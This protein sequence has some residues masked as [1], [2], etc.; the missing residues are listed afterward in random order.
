MSLVLTQSEEA[1]SERQRTLPLLVVSSLAL[2]VLVVA[3][4]PRPR[5]DASRAPLPVLTAVFADDAPAPTPAERP[6]ESEPKPAEDAR[7]AQ[8]PS[9][10][11][12]VT[13]RPAAVRAPAPAAAPSGAESP[14]DAPA[15]FTST[16]L[17]S[18]G[19][20]VAVPPGGGGAPGGSAR[21]A[22]PGP[23]YATR[24]QAGPRTVAVA[25]LARPPRAP[26]LDGALEQHYPIDARRGGIAGSAVLRVQVLPDGRVGRV[27]RISE[28]YAGFGGACEAAVRSAPWAPPLD[29][30]GSAVTT[31]LNY[32]CRFEVRS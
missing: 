11:R 8:R 14:A 23:A 19:P 15:D 1:A 28:T 26:R 4:I 25:D 20:G 10:L 12:A 31:E 7:A 32:T 30:S 17:S 5:I 24:A 9:A 2:H 27:V 16:V 21:G 22:A 3:V 6:H 13:A 29:R 18:D